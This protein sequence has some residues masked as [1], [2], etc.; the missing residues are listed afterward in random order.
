M[1]KMGMEG[2]PGRAMSEDEAQ[3]I[4]IGALAHIAADEALLTRFVSVT[5]I[6]PGAIRQAATQPHFLAGVLDFLLGHEPD[7]L[8]FA[9]RFGVPPEDVG[10]ARLALSGEGD[11][12]PWTSV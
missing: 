8:D 12:E 10:R 11:P 7:A 4:A 1:V 9:A 2:R 3:R 5:G 6:E